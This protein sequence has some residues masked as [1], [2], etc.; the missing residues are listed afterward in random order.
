MRE[1]LQQDLRSLTASVAEMCGQA[2]LAMER[3]TGA[4]LRADLELAE[5][6]IT[7]LQ[8]IAPKVA[9][10]EDGAFKLLAL[11]APVAGDLRAVVSSLQNVADVQRMHALARHVAKMARRRHPDHAVPE[12]VNGYFAEMGRI[13]V[14]MV[15]MPETL[16]FQV[17]R[18]RPQNSMTTT[19]PW[20][21]CTAIYSQC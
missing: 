14:D 20:T 5:Q 19:T 18:P 4:L 3:A 12:D 2:G 15:T 11:Q 16:C 21:T 17:I 9:G 7:G 10:T 1:G 8:E 13:A 6:V